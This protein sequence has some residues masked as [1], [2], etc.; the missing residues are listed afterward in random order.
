MTDYLVKGR[1][2]DYA[3]TPGDKLVNY[4]QVKPCARTRLST[5]A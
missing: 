1:I 5:L 2:D 4:S 3:S